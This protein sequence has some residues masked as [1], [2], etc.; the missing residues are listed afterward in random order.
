MNARNYCHTCEQFRD[1]SELD[2]HVESDPFGTGDTWYSESTI[3]CAT[4]KGEDIE[5]VFACEACED[6]LPLEDFDDCARCILRDQYTHDKTYDAEQYAEARAIMRRVDP[7][8][9]LVID[10][11]IAR[12]IDRGR[13]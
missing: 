12:Q 6:A 10:E 2:E 11:D 3:S 13:S 9:L 1:A 5:E 4:C 7:A 8:A